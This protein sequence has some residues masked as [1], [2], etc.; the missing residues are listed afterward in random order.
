MAP[1]PVKRASVTATP[2]SEVIS[3][4][5]KGSRMFRMNG[6]YVARVTSVVA[7]GGQRQVRG[8]D[9]LERTECKL[10]RELRHNGNEFVANPVTPVRKLKRPTLN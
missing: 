4:L 7:V 1:A 5:S 8:V 9:K 10:D 3:R 6:C 2:A